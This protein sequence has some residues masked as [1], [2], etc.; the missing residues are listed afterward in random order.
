GKMGYIS[1]MSDSTTRF[2]DRV[3]DYVKYRPHYPETVIEYLRSTYGL[4]SGWDIADIGSGTGISTELFLRN[5][6]RVYGI[7]PNREMRE[8]AEQL[9]AGYAERRGAEGADGAAAEGVAAAGAAAGGG[10]FISIDGTA[11]V[12]GLPD[13]SVDM[14]VAGQAFHWFDPKKSRVE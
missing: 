14:I 12:T 3:E 6:N 8:K 1:Q 7:E 2:S 9:L 10:N 11:E 4:T 5:G 13:D